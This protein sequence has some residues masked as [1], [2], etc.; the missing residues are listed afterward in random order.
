VTVD[1]T[2]EVGRRDHP[3][4]DDRWYLADEREFLQRSL[5]D[6]EREHGAGDLSDEDHAVLVARDSARLA[7]VEAELA[8]LPEP[9]VA[10]AAQPA[11][12]TAPQTAPQT[13]RRPLPLWRRIGIAAACLLIATGLGILVVHFVQARQPGQA[14]SGSVTLSQA[15]QIEQQLAQ[16]L[17]LNNDGNTKAALEL[18]DKVLSED[19][20]NPAALAYAGYLQWNVGSSAHVAALVKIGR[21][22]IETSVR[23]SP[24]YY[25]GHLFYGLVLENQDHDDAAAV[26]QFGDFLADDPP[27]AEPAQ[28]AALVAGAYQGAGVPVPSAFS[29]GTKTGTTSAP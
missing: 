8:A 1:G 23:D 26:T 29:G 9:T 19:P 20:S 28:V 12:P 4:R 6:A 5:D 22:E 21:A 14:A 17:V 7:E 16:A 24:S 10:A 27:A 13:E 2:A 3:E 18:Y 11:V 15:Q 25:Q